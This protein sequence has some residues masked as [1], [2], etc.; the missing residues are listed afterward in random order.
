MYRES[1]LIHGRIAMMG[2]LGYLVQSHFAPLFDM[3]SIEL[4]AFAHFA[5]SVP[6]HLLEE[7]GALFSAFALVLSPS[8]TSCFV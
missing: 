2:A 5:R 3:V 7:C 6:F 4:A 1:E 8:H